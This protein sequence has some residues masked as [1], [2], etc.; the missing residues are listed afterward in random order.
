MNIPP[1]MV[2]HHFRCFQATSEQNKIPCPPESLDH[3]PD[4]SEQHASLAQ[5]PAG[6]PD[7][8][9]A[10]TPKTGS[11]NQTGSNTQSK[12]VIKFSER[13]ILKLKPANISRNSAQEQPPANKPSE[14]TSMTAVNNEIKLP[15]T[16]QPDELV[17]LEFY[18]KNPE[19]LPVL[20][21]FQMFL[22][23]ERKR[24]RNRMLAMTALFAMLLI[25]IAGFSLFIGMFFASQIQNDM[26][27]MQKDFSE[28]KSAANKIKNEADLAFQRFTLDTTKLRNEIIEGKYAFDEAKSGVDSRIV[29]YDSK[30]DKINKTMRMLE[31][32]NNLLKNNI[33]SIRSEIKP[34]AASLAMM[35]IAKSKPDFSQK[36]IAQ[37]LIPLEPSIMAMTIQPPGKS[38]T[39]IW[40]LPIP[41]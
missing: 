17:P 15:A 8:S 12:P 39:V 41:E 23:T 28:F 36:T 18:E 26:K 10:N 22:D 20:E 6:G 19:S 37:N 24:A 32:E 16:R 14:R 9:T 2:S 35:E 3:I 31:Q 38:G 25:I 29:G 33:G 40:Y 30:L 27:D 21:A 11:D 13:K 1:K 34:L 5:Q 4:T 7:T